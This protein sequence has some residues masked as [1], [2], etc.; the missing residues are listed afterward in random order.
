MW[1]RKPCSAFPWEPAQWGRVSSVAG[2]DL[3][4]DGW[5][6]HGESSWTV[7]PAQPGAA[8]SVPVLLGT[9]G[10]EAGEG[11]AT[12]TRRQEIRIFPFPFSPAPVLLCC[13]HFPAFRVLGQ[14]DVIAV[15]HP[16]GDTEREG[17]AK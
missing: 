14:S 15:Q 4:S 8:P 12:C 7:L 9:A 6:E 1:G 5:G 11:F 10:L 2:I 16:H 17:D 13:V 3:C